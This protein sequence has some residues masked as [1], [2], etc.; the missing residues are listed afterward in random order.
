M[1]HGGHLRH[2]ALARMAALGCF[3]GGPSGTLQDHPAGDIA[4]CGDGTSALQGAN[5]FYLHSGTVKSQTLPEAAPPDRLPPCA[6][7]IVLLWPVP[8]KNAYSPGFKAS[9]NVIL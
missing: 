4:S 2:S 9:P 1:A 8:M 6:P 7:A 5:H 3:A